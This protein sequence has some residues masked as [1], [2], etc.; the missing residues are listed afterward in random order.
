M[1]GDFC[2]FVHTCLWRIIVC[3]GTCLI[4][5][6]WGGQIPHFISIHVLPTQHNYASY[7]ADTPQGQDGQ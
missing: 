7:M 6:L 2:G 5:G 3:S 4:L 1:L